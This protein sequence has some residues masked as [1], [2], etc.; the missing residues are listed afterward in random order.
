MKATATKLIEKQCQRHLA[1]Q[2]ITSQK[3]LEHRLQEIF[4]RAEHQSSALVDIYK[5]II[6]DWEQI[7]RLEGYPVVGRGLWQYIAN[8]FIDFDQRNHPQIFNGGLWLNQGFSSSNEIGPWE[9]SM[10]RCNVIYF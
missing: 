8:L 7:E 6:P 5:L 1:A 2:G 4:E 9:I 3:K 10:D